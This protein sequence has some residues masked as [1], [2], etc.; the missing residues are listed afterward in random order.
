MKVDEIRDAMRGRI[1]QSIAQ[2]GVSL[3][4]LPKADQDAL[5]ERIADDVLLEMDELIGNPQSEA[6]APAPPPLAQ[7]ATKPGPDGE[8]QILW[9]GRPFLTPFVHYLLTSERLLTT[10]GI[11]GRDH[12][13][14]E[15]VRVKDVDWHQGLS[16]RVLGIGDILIVSVDSTDPRAVLNNVH[17]PEEVF[18]IVRRAMLSARKKYHIIFEQQM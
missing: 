18:E 13:N 3:A 9:E 16:E 1:W 12:D 10:R 15:L 8:E 7:S 5:V 14:L 6:G 17:H 11:F 4:A 2:S